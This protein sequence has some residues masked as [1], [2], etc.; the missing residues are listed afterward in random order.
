MQSDGKAT[1]S[2]LSLLPAAS[3]PQH[4]S[5][6]ASRN[7]VKH[8][9]AQADAPQQQHSNLSSPH[10]S[11]SP[12]SSATA[13]I[14]QGTLSL[15]PYEDP[16][17]KRARRDVPD[18]FEPG[19]VPRS[20][21]P[22]LH[23]L[24]AGSSKTCQRRIAIEDIVAPTDSPPHQPREASQLESPPSTVRSF[25]SNATATE[26]SQPASA[27]DR[28]PLSVQHNTLP[29]GAPGR[30]L[31]PR[32]PAHPLAAS[33]RQLVQSSGTV[34]ARQNPTTSHSS[35]SQFLG[36]F[37]V[38]GYEA[39]SLATA[40]LSQSTSAHGC[41]TTN[42]FSNPTQ[43]SFG[44]ERLCPARIPI[45]SSGGQNPYRMM[46]LETSSGTVQLPVNVQAASRAADEKR[47]RGACA[48]ARFRQRRKDKEKEASIII[49][50]LERQVKEL[51]DLADI[52][53]RERDL[54]QSILSTIP[55]CEWYLPRPPSPR[56]GRSQEHMQRSQ[57]VAHPPP[58][59]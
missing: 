45:S 43:A 39:T 5:S 37:P 27:R 28:Q 12:A 20:E 25:P 56:L 17:N 47:Q 35:Y 31:T 19:V 26:G 36:T 58:P 30:I 51:G 57:K 38:T 52:Y 29:E 55:G 1:A 15:L 4:C 13:P 33:R 59:L 41:S 21:R 18:T 34:S 9:V 32:Y 16:R 42:T 6:I 49:A 46:A 3:F 23:S 7:M 22:P 14:P 8:S 50:R 10:V 11:S 44:L 24:P 40:P 54:L 48:S 53:R 2:S